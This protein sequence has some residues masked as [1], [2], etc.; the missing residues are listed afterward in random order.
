[1]SVRISQTLLVLGVALFAT[2]VVWNNLTDYGSNLAYVRHVL[3]MDTTFPGNHGLW[4][5][6]ESD[7]VHHLAY[8]LI[9]ASEAAIAAL[10]WLGG[11]RMW[12]TRS[13]DAEFERARRIA[14]AGLT[15]GVLLWFVGFIVIGGEWFLMWQ[16]E[17]WDARPAATMFAVIISLVLIYVTH[18]EST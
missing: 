9:I 4:R 16:S 14:V 12:R 10:C 15:G 17:K 11:Y 6:I 8:A 1:M 3:S 18:P 2:L 7:P 13:A 5:R